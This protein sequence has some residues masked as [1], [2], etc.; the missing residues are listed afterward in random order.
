VAESDLEENSR[1][2]IVGVVSQIQYPVTIEN[3]TFACKMHNNEQ[4]NDK[5]K[6]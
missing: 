4:I 3:D 5:C 1:K 2:E 6:L